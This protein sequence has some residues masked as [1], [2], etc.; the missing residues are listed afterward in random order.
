MILRELNWS[1]NKI[2]VIDTYSIEKSGKPFD[3]LGKGKRK[4]KR[5]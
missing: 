2:L 5:L 1:K 3:N 4:V